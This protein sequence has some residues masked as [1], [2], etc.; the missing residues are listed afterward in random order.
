MRTI[1]EEADASR[2]NP[3][4]NRLS[5]QLYLIA[6]LVS[7]G[8]SVVPVEYRWIETTGLCCTAAY[9]GYL[10]FSARRG[11]G[12]LWDAI[13][14]KQWRFICSL[15]AIMPLVLCCLTAVAAKGT[16]IER[17]IALLGFGISGCIA[18][19]LYKNSKFSPGLIAASGAFLIVM[20]LVSTEYGHAQVDEVAH[21]RPVP[22]IVR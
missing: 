16:T 15:V 14:K 8:C 17:L 20:F 11:G 7:L 9:A 18:W 5:Y 12:S 21:R 1:R 19:S 22:A 3:L 10:Y 13:D 6:F 2:E 4:P